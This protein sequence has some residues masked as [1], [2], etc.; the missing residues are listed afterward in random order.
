MINSNLTKCG[1]CG[2]EISCLA[3]RCPSCGAPNDWVHP[4][5]QHFID[6]TDD[7]FE[8][9][10][11][12]DYEYNKLR[13]TGYTEKKTPLWVYG[14]AVLLSV[15][16]FFFLGHRFLYCFDYIFRSTWLGVSEKQVV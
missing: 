13:L 3:D 8:V 10:K 11:E 1:A 4:K 14:V 9:S 6:S 12:Y 15:P 5:I 2:K 7:K 16:F